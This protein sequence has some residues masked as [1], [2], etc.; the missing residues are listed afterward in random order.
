MNLLLNCQLNAQC[1][2]DCDRQIF[3]LKVLACRNHHHDTVVILLEMEEADED[4]VKCIKE[5][6]GRQWQ[7]CH[8]QGHHGHYAH[9]IRIYSTVTVSVMVPS[10]FC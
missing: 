10:R 4:I 9:R 8:R 5:R 7:I 2:S 1:T 6:D 3:C